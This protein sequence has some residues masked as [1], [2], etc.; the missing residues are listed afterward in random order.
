MDTEVGS[1]IL[2]GRRRPLLPGVL[3]ALALVAV[4]TG[5]IY[6]LKQ[7]TTAPSLGVVYLVGVVVV[8]AY[9]G[10]WLGLATS[11]ASAVAF[12][13]F[14]IPPVGRFTIA[15]SRN[16]VALATFLVA[17][18]VT[19]TVSQRAWLRTRE[20]ERG[21]AEADLTRDMAQLLLAEAGVHDA[22]ALIG[23]RLAQV[24]ELPWAQISLEQPG[25]DARRV[26][27]ALGAAAD[28]VGA[29]VIP[30]GV[31]PRTAQRLHAIV[32]PALSALLG[33]VRERERLVSEAVETEGL[34]RSEA[35]K[36]AVLRAVSHD[37]RSPVTAMIAAGAAVRAPGLS[38][39][40][41]DELGRVVEGEGTRLARL[42]EDLLSLSR[43]ESQAATPRLEECSLEEVIDAALAAQPDEAAFD[44]RVDPDLPPVRADFAQ[45]ER[46]VANLM[47][48]ASRFRAGQP[49]L[50]RARPVG[51]RVVV[52]VIDRGP[53]IAEADQARI[54]EPFYRSAGQ[55][56]AD[57]HPGSGL[58]LAIAKG[59]VEAGG[60]RIWVESVLGHGSTFVVE[61]PASRP[62]SR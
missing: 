32:V 19:S 4:C 16:W 1:S 30:T 49:V 37:L 45:L 33:M 24:F 2:R 27:I 56:E 3:V 10:L 42:I 21:R 11:V 35:V 60:G 23:H 61:L 39:A 7:I 8:S 53:G 6:P 57:H 20:A 50:I 51:D 9:W 58:G 54:F 15:D 41:R 43:L 44:A 59:F 22:L 40:E 38:Q 25:P 18:I 47:E 34:R 5:L 55:P 48:N 26:V 36:T 14:H 52:R 46:A 12:N 17:A 13:F 28:P 62:E 29:L 31:S